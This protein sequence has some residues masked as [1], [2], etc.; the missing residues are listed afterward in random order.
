MKQTFK[1]SMSILL[2]FVMVVSIL[3]SVPTT[4][5]AAGVDYKHNAS[6]STDE[7]YNLISKTDW[8][9][10]PG[11]SESEIV[12][13][14]DAGDDRQV[15]HVMKADINNSYVEV[16]PTYSEMNTSKY[17]TGTMLDQA[18]WIDENMEGE[19]IG[20]MNCCLS[21]YTGYVAE[22]VGEPL[23]FMMLNGE[24]M[25]DP[26]NCG[27]DYG[28]VGF[29]TCV[30]IN[31]DTNEAGEARPADIPKLEMVQINSS[32]DLDGWED[33]V[34]PISSGYIVKDGVNQAA[35]SH[36]GKEPRSVVGITADGEVVIMEVDGRQSPFSSGMNMY[37][38]AE[39]MIAAGCVWAANCDGGGSSTFVSQRPGEE[40]KVNN[41][42]SD[43][44]L[45]P[46]T[47]GICFISTAP[48]DGQ[49]ARANIT[50]SD[51][52]Y[53]P[54]SEIQFNAVGTD[55]VGNPAEL[56]EDVIWQLTD[57]NVGTISNTGLFTSNGTT[58]SV[59][60]QLVYE[61]E[62][63][64]EATI[65]IVIPEISF[66]Q[67]TIVI[68]YGD[69][70]VL[71]V[72]VTTN[73]GRN[74]VTY[75]VGDIVYTLSDENLGT[76]DGDNFTACDESVGLTN[77]TITAV[78][79]GQTD[80]KVS[81][82]IRFGKASE[83]AYDFED[84]QFPVDTSK[85]GNIGGD[86]AADTGEYIYGWH[87][88]DTRANGHFSYRY[89][90]KKNYTPIGYDIPAQVYLVDQSNGMVRNGNYAMGIDID[91]TYV[92]AS[93]H[94][95]M[96]IHLPES[97][98]LT[99][100]TRVG[101]WMYIP[102]ELV[103]DSMQIRV[104]F[105]TTAGG[106]TAVTNNITD[107]VG[108]TSGVKNGGWF[109][110]S[111]EVL[112]NYK[113]FDYIQI[114]SHY[115][116]GAGKY[117][118]YQDVT[119]YVDDITVDYSDAT[120]D[121][122]NPYFTS[123]TITDE[124][125]NGEEI[126]GQTI[127]T[128]NINLM[129]QAY[130]NTTKTNATGLNRNSVKLYID[131]AL[132]D[133]DIAVY[134]G[135]TIS[136]SDLYLND[137]VHT[138]VME[139]CD[140]QGNV[141][142]IVR[143]VVV[144]T[145]KSDVRLEVPAPTVDLLPTGSIYWLN[146]VADNLSSIDS[147]TT[148]INLDYV[149]DW[150]LEGMEVAYGFKAEYHINNHNDA[151]ITFTR[152]GT[153][154][155]DTTIL[156]KLPV[157]I[158]MAKGWMDDSGIRKDYISN[159]PAKQ[160]KYYILTPHAMWYSDGTR[161]YRL[162]VSAEA[163][164]VTYTDGN[165]ETFSANETV[166]QTEMNRYYT[167]PD[168]QGKWSFHICT[169]GVAQSK[170]P[171][172]TESG[173]EN[174]VF[175]AGCACGSVEN[176]GTECDTH[177]GCGSVVDWGT[178]IPAM[179]HEYE[180]NTDGKLVC[181]NGGEL[182][183]GVYTDG[184]TYVDGVVIVDGWNADKTCYYVDGVKVVGQKL[185]D[186]IMCTFDENGIY[187]SD[188]KYDGWYE[189]DDTVMFFVSNTYLTGFQRLSNEFYLFDENG[190]GYDGIYDFCGIEVQY[191]NGLVVESEDV[192]YAGLCGEDVR[193]VILQNG[194]MIVDGTGPMDSYS[195]VSQ[196]PWY[197]NVNYRNRVTSL[198]IGENVTTVGSRAFMDMI[199][200]KT[201]E[202]AE[203]SNVVQILAYAFLRDQNLTEV[204]LPEKVWTIG[205]SAFQQCGKLEKVYVPANV[206]YLL[207]DA[208][209]QTNNVVLQ[210]AD[211]SIAMQRA[212][213]LGIK[214]EIYIPKIA[215][216]SCGDNL[217]WEIYE[218]GT[219]KIL[220]SGEMNNY[221]AY[222]SNTAPWRKYNSLIKKV[223]I[224]SDVTYIGKFAFYSCG[225][226]VDVEFET[227]SELEVIGWGAFGAC[228]S[229][230]AVI[231]PA[232]VK[233]LNDYA[234]YNCLALESVDFAE[235][236]N[237][238][239][240]GDYA[241]WNDVSLKNVFV[242][243]GVLEIKSNAFY[244]TGSVTLSVMEGGPAH[245]FAVNKKLNFTTRPAE[246]ILL[247]NG[248]AGETAQWEY[249]SDGTLK[250]LGSGAMN[251]YEAYDYNTAPWRK[252]N[253]LIKK[254]VIG[255]EIT[256]I[257]KFS[258][259]GCSKLTTFEFESKSHV[260]TIGWGA[261]GAC[262]SLKTI[263]IPSSVKELSDY[264]FYNCAALENVDFA[265]NSKLSV[266][267]DYAFWN[268][269]SL[270]EVFIPN[271]VLEIKTNAFYATGD[272]TLSVME[273]SPAH[274]FA[275]NKNIDFTIRAAEAM[276]LESGQCGIDV[277]WEFYNDGTLKILGAGAMYDYNA[278]DSNLSPWR[279]YNSQIKKIVIG[280]EITYIGKF[281]F[282]SCRKLITIEFEENSSVETIGWGAFGECDSLKT[283]VIPSSV[284]NLLCYAFYNCDTL[285]EV[286][287]AEDSQIESIGDYAFWND[288][289][290]N[291]ISGVASD[292]KLGIGT[293]LGT[294]YIHN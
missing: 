50:T 284:K 62:V 59:T 169:P 191:D 248:V 32:S 22:R 7:Y 34:I 257:G 68:G 252:Y 162:V 178:I 87:I 243:S 219:L 69:S 217:T 224:G 73:E 72:E 139:I 180:V 164:V 268:D 122:E 247:A 267:G 10:A 239:T 185:I 215:S 262:N 100:A 271:N 168:R 280:N 142:N 235:N 124:N 104:G 52:Y 49:F 75:S 2:A 222:D 70:M 92:T 31:K 210:V 291:S 290:L 259:Y 13:N 120:I 86:D 240:I 183:N 116:A 166:I 118:Y 233:T 113:T 24:I 258:F 155:A 121:R 277:E 57:N 20:V 190:K 89:Y 288:I 266:I 287:F 254:V 27:Y 66:K 163:G 148:T 282:Y 220:G 197:G 198:Y 199:N 134:V 3:A 105:H 83:I 60:A 184:K 236:S 11:I 170:A 175:C 270:K 51:T 44:V 80:N 42:P 119:Y 253:S 212:I 107:F 112:D 88:N 117:N 137:G 29:P 133:A 201:V 74:T 82:N 45:R 172:C 63:V 246:P 214:Y 28:K 56:P 173:Y 135:G 106:T 21:W 96:D 129:A 165:T 64:G 226:L 256:Y 241:F 182:F 204:I 84:G 208:F 174:R 285:T 33:T 153:E 211:G 193:F 9:N 275:V 159:D 278:Y 234:F 143:K 147:V 58:G 94:G 90:A 274:V 18:N 206:H 207:S 272:V 289:S 130:E 158:W 269:T 141:G 149:N 232:S 276:M 200:L 202:F 187:L 251:D 37:E 14:N 250:I 146:L 132:S 138:I 48:A 110:F 194:H 53:T 131:G 1:R 109:Y 5:Y 154:V 125:G 102:A 238:S 273:G 111:W 151:V 286:I 85:T 71:P 115:T 230:K 25:F 264:A 17:Q 195:N 93:C 249:Y 196:N 156:A 8:D 255:N 213:E 225:Q 279:K 218:D 35:A 152:T 228:N 6:T 95:Q 97:L 205:S 4:A 91:W 26:G 126:S 186:G 12:L 65:N 189:I 47:S 61:G 294:G 263:V 128:N 78:I 136:V 23:G 237:L 292:V 145:E 101:F 242:P 244:A 67:D 216:G 181:V 103:T 46:S 192:L 43:G 99:D 41:S 81:A 171:T 179:G 144:N 229:L 40:L 167:N 188:Y 98:D 77:G 209:Y 161:D 160:D 54:N 30:V 36:T 221:E 265:E 203:G 261:F 245:A 157:R 38:C 16:I 19:V 76:I 176:L 260:H 79:C 39:V 140:N 114:N 227:D 127:T 108:E 223:V 150:E 281:A 293:F 15:V 123:M 177:S 283:V 231:L 55:L